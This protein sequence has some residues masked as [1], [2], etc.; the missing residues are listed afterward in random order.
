M[1]KCSHIFRI[2]ALLL[3]IT[4]ALT[5]AS[6]QSNDEYVELTPPEVDFDMYSSYGLDIEVETDYDNMSV[7]TEKSVY[8]LQDEYIKCKITNNNVGKGF[9]FYN[10]PSIQKKVGDVWETLSY[11]TTGILYSRYGFC[12]VED[13]NERSYTTTIRLYINRVTPK[14]EKG[15][16][17]IV[18][19]TPMKTFYA[20]FSME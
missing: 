17:R 14:M 6:C 5:L 9:Y 16:Y 15:D 10:T 8:S 19:F 1:K 18:I 2:S 11:D 3:I 12:G 4:L 20:E 7:Y 13:D